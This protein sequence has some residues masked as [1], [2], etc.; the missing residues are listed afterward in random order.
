MEKQMSTYKQAGVNIELGDICSHIMSEA[1]NKTFTNRK[2][3]IGEVKVL[4][5][6]GLHRVITLSFGAF[7]IMLNS[8]GIG[9]KVE[10]A[11]R[12]RKHD[13]MAYDLFAMLC[14]DSVRYGAEPVAISNILDV[15]SLDKEVVK[16]LAKGMVKAA[17]DADVSIISGEIAE[18]GGRI[19]GYG[20][21]NYNWGGTVLS[22]IKKHIKSNDIQPEDTIIAFQEKGFRSNG[23]SLV[24]KI[25]E[26]EYGHQWHDKEENGKTLG[27]MV[28]TP[29]IIYSKAVLD[30]LDYVKSVVH[31]TGGG[32]P[33]KLGRVLQNTKLGAD[34]SDPLPPCYM[35][36]LCQK[37][38]NI[39]DKEAYLAW[40]MGHGMML[41]TSTPEKVIEVLKKHKIKT[42]IVGTINKKE[43][44][45]ICS[46]GLFEK[47]KI[48]EF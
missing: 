7:K 48:L 18:L 46:R 4:E 39:S 21:T 22:I 24:R 40:N 20:K 37:K 23:I 15:S 12:M 43:K 5:E 13:T 6:K 14:D 32:I 35:M 31:I 25:M 44:I 17:Q 2:G 29:S 9:T 19:S 16:Q 45:R 3:K 30:V 11:E 34:I 10:I 47:G 28:L 42:K 41:I 8:D 26:E 38:G 36:S 33:K 1:S 27:E